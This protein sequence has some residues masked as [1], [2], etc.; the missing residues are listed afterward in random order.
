MGMSVARM[1]EEFSSA[2]LTDWMAYAQVEPF[3]GPV[4][5]MRAGLAPALTVNM[6]RERGAEP[7]SW[8][9][10]YPWHREPKPEPKPQTPQE[11]VAA[12][13]AITTRKAQPDGDQ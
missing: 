5:D 1:L 6:N 13:R 2:E 12:L 4:E 9:D 11:I 7:I 10:F 3:G 8:M